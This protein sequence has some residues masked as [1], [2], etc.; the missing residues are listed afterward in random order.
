MMAIESSMVTADAIEAIEF[1]EL[2]QAH[3]VRGVPKT[4]VNDGVAS[5]EGA[6]PEPQ[7]IATVMQAAKPE[8]SGD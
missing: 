2:A 5:M 3:R 6:Y 8:G 1:Q 4:V 7:F